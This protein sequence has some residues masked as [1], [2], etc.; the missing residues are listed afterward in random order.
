MAHKAEISWTRIDDEGQKFQVFARHV[1][2]R[3]VFFN[4]QGRYEEWQQQEHPPLEDWLQL[5][6]AIRRRVQRR[7]LRP[8]EIQRVEKSIRKRFPEATL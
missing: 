3:W 1:G 5:L 4:R 8:E 7:K 6:D 2:N